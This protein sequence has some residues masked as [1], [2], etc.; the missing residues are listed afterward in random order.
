MRISQDVLLDILSSCHD[1]LEEIELEQVQMKQVSAEML[2]AMLAPRLRVLDLSCNKIGF[3][4]F[5]QILDK[6]LLEKKCPNIRNLSLQYNPV[7]Q[8]A[9][10]Q[11]LQ[12]YV[13]FL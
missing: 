7:F 11:Q 1:T 9:E 6:I 5:Q 13:D 4:Q 2:E 8:D 12:K 3:S 10:P